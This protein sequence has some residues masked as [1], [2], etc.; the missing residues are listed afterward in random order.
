MPIPLSRC[1]VSLSH[2]SGDFVTLAIKKPL[3]LSQSLSICGIHKKVACSPNVINKSPF[4]FL[5]FPFPFFR[6]TK[7]S[8]YILKQSKR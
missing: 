4:A 2:N 7:S 1:F 3:S 6:Q 5:A 8:F